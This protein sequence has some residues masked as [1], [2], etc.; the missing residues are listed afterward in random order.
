M[1]VFFKNNSVV[2]YNVSNTTMANDS[3]GIVNSMQDI[4]FL[5]Q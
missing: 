4:Q 5:F 1:A 2:F 3:R